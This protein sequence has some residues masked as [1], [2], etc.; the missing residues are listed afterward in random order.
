MTKDSNYYEILE[1]ASASD[2]ETIRQAYQRARKT[3]SID[4]V[5]AYSLFSENEL[6]NILEKIEEAYFVL[7]DPAKEE[8]MI[9]L[10]D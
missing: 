1:V 4:S 9:K 8:L 7:G 6:K 10:R 3:Y 2:F 5:S